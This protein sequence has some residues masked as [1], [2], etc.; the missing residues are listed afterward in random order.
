MIVISPSY[1]IIIWFPVNHLRNVDI[2][3]F[4]K[5]S[6]NRPKNFTRRTHVDDGFCQISIFPLSLRKRSFIKYLFSGYITL[7]SVE[8]FFFSVFDIPGKDV[9]K[10]GILIRRGNPSLSLSARPNSFKN[11]LLTYCYFIFSYIQRICTMHFISIIYAWW[12]PQKIT[13]FVKSI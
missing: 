2:P 7:E 10:K 13:S 3:P 9:W 8:D 12:V 11:A 4:L 1:K 5:S 6:A